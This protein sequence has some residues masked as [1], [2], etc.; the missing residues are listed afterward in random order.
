MQVFNQIRFDLDGLKP[1]WLCDYFFKKYLRNSQLPEDNGKLLRFFLKLT[2]LENVPSY[3]GDFFEIFLEVE[4]IQ[5]KFIRISFL[6]KIGMLCPQ[7]KTSNFEMVL[8]S[9]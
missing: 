8:F 7:K 9:L 2:L 6:V 4:I 1:I 3:L 5:L